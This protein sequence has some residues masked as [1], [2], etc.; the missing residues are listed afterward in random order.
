MGRA[1]IL[2]SR[3]PGP[4]FVGFRA[5][6]SGFTPAQAHVGLMVFPGLTTTTAAAQE[7]DCS[8]TTPPKSAIAAYNTSPV[9]SVV[10]LSSDYKNANGTFNTS[11]NLVR[12]ARGGGSGCSAGIT[13]YGGVGTF[14]ADAVS[15]AQSYLSTNGRANVPKMIILLSD[16]DAGASPSN[17]ENSKKQNQCKQAIT[18]ANQATAA[19][20]T[21]ITIAYGAPRT[22]NTSPNGSC[23]TDT[24][25]SGSRSACTTLQQM[26][27]DST[28]FYSD[29]LGGTNACTVTASYT[30]D[31]TIPFYGTYPIPLSASACF[32]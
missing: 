31:M 25:A 11:S 32:P 15:A 20:T 18:A 5:L 28:Y 2:S 29:T 24:A 17:M 21:V 23:A 1:P 8:A 22:P 3:P 10:P 19:K 27:S 6:L 26:A 16:G 13:A 14:Y 7:Y 12:A 4:A 30:Y 9:Y